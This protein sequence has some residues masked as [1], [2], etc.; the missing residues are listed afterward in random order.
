MGAI[1]RWLLERN[2]P[3][4][5]F[6]TSNV[7]F[8]LMRD[9]AFE[10]FVAN[11]RELPARADSVLIRA[12]FD[13]GRPHPVELPGYRSVTLLQ[14]LPRFLELHDAGAY[15]NDWDVCTVDYLP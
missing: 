3:V 9:G 2:E 4:S 14:R 6:Y 8:Y 12:C 15:A 13:Y 7:E 5:A 1:G 11:L 10:P